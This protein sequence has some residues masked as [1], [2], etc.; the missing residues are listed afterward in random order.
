M[1]RYERDLIVGVSPFERPDPA[2][3]VGLVR[4]GALG[5]LDL[6]RDP[7][8]A[9]KALNE[10]TRWTDESFGVRVPEAADHE[11]A[12]LPD[13]VDTVVLADADAVA[14]WA[15]PGRR[16]LVE[17]RSP[18]EA[19]AALAAGA[20]GLIAKGAES[21]GRIGDL[22]A[23][24]LLQTLVARTDRPVWCQGGIGRHTAAAA[25]AGGAA[26]V[27][28][29]AQLALVRESTLPA[30]VRQAVGAMDGS[31][32]V[33]LGEHRVFTR[34]DLPVASA[35]PD[36]PAADV[37]AALGADDLRAQYL[38]VGQDGAFAKGLAERF[39]TAGG[40]A[41]GL[42]LAIDEHLDAAT[43]APSLAEHST[44]ATTLGTRYPI[45]QG[46]M[47]RVSDRAAFAAAV[48]DGGGLP[49]LALALMS[50]DEVRALLE[51]T[52]PLLGD[53]PWGVGILGFVPPEVREAQLEVVHDVRPPVALIA[54]GR[55]SQAAPLEAAG[56]STFLHVPSPGLLDLF[57]REGARK[58][59]FEG[60]E[61]GGH[62]G[63]RSSFALWDAQ[64]EH[65]LAFGHTDEVSVLFAGGVHDARS[66]AMVGALAAPLAEAGAGV[67]VLMGTSY[68]FTEEAVAGGAILPGF[69]QAAVDC[70]RTVL[71]E[72]SPGHA[73]RC[74]ESD[75]VRA[76]E[77]EK[78]RLLGEGVSVQ[79]AWAELEQLNLGRLR[80]ATKGV[81]REGGQIV[82]VDE[83]GQRREGMFMI[84]QAATLRHEVT[85][86][87][88][89]HD[90]V[91]AGS[92]K[93]LADLGAERAAASGE[94]EAGA[95]LSLDIAI[96]GMAA[97]FAGAADTAHYWSNVVGGVN[98]ITEVPAARWDA[99]RYYD[100][101]AFLNDAGRKT[102][103]RWGGF[104]PEVPFD[105]LAYGI[106]PT[107]LASIEPG[108][109][110]SLEMAARALA[111]AGYATREFDR[112]RTSVVFGAEGGTDLATAY[113]FRALFQTYVGDLPEALDDY[114]PAYTED[115]FP[116]LL[117]N[118]ISGRIANRLDLGGSN[119]TVDAACASALAAIDVACKELVAGTS[120]MVLA[121]GADL[122]NG[123]NDY[124]LFSSVHALSP[125][126]QCRTFDAD[127]DGITLGEGVG[128]LVL[129]RL[130][131][132]ERD[133]DRIY[134]VLRGMAASSDG[135][136]LGLTAPRKEGQRLALD[137]AYDQAGV[138]PA[139]VGLIE[140][141]GTGTVVGDRTELATLTEFF[142]E[143]DAPA[144]ATS[145]GSVK[146]QI[147]HTKCAAGVAGLIKATEAV[148]RRVRPPT[149]NIERPT[150]FYDA[151]TSPFRFDDAARPWTDAQ[152]VAGVSAFGF[153]G[154][155]FHAV[156]SSYDGAPTPAH[157]LDRWP[158]E[159]FVFRGA[160]QGAALVAIDAVAAK[161][162]AERRPGLP[163]HLRDLAA[164]AAERA[165]AAAHAGDPVQV[166]VVADDVDDLLAKLEVARTFTADKAGVVV[167]D[168][169]LQEPAG[170]ETSTGKLAFLF[171][172]QGSQR[173]G[174]LR[175]LFVAFPRLQRH[176]RAPYTDVM[177]PPAAHS[178][179][180]VKAQKEAI[181]DTRV[182]QPTLGI[183]GLAMYDLLTTLGVRP[184]LA[185]GHS[186]GELVA[187]AAAGALA[188]D[189]LVPLSET[190]ARAILGA[191][192]D[193][194]GAMA[195]VAGKGDDVRAVLASLPAEH[196]VVLANDNAPGQAV[197]SGPTA[198]V[199]VAVA[200]LA[201]AGL[202]SK[203]LPV[204]CAFHCPVVADA[205]I[206]LGEAVAEATVAAPAFPVWS[207]TT[208]EPYPAGVDDVRSL[209]SNQVAEPVRWVDEIESMY[210]AGARV[211]VES[212]PGRVLTQ[213]V[214]KILGDRPH[215]AVACDASGEDGLRRFLVALAQLAAN[216]VDVDV[217]PL[218]DGRDA[219]AE[220]LTAAAKPAGWTI[221]G[222][223]VRGA[224][225]RP[226]AGSLQPVDTAPEVVLAAG[227]FGAGGAAGERD[228]AVLEYLRGAREL[229]A[230]EREVM[231][232]YLGGTVEAAAPLGTV[233]LAPLTT[234]APAAIEASATDAG[235][236]SPSG[237][238]AVLTPDEV[239][240]AVLAIVSERTGYPLDMLDP[241]LDLEADLS[242]DSIKR[243]EI[244]GELA[245][246]V[247]LPGADEGSIDESVVEEL[248]Q[249]KT[250]RGIVDWIGAL[251]DREGAG[252]DA[253]AAVADAAGSD[254]G[255]PGVVVPAATLRY[256]VELAEV[257][258]ADDPPGP[259]SGAFAGQTFAVVDDGQGVALHLSALLE[260]R[261]ATVRL[262]A[263]DDAAALSGGAAEVLD[264]LVHLAFLAHGTELPLATLFA[265][266]KGPVLGGLRHLVVATG[267]GGGFGRGPARSAGD[268]LPASSG[269]HGLA[270]T[271]AREF[272]D[273]RVLAI[274]LDPK[275]DPSHLAEHL[276]AELCAGDGLVD[277]GRTNGTRQTLRVLPA[278]LDE[279]AVA[280]APPIVGAD[281]VVLLT[282]GAR[283]ITARVAVALA[284][285]GCGHLVLVGR[286][287]LPEGDE[288]PATAGAADAVE[289]RK[290][291][292]GEGLKD[293][294]A[295]EA[296]C[297]RILAERE[298]RATLRTIADLGAEATYH[299]ADVRD[300]AALEAIV[301][302]TYERCGRLDGVV[303]GAG[304]LEDRFLR[305][306]TAESFE[307]VFGTKVDGARTLA[308]VVR[309]DVG[310]L[311]LFGSIAGVFGNRG[312]VDYAAAND[313]LDTL[314]RRAAEHLTGRVVSVDWGPWAGTGMVSAELEREYG[315]R[316]IGLIDPD[317]GVACLLH[318]LRSGRADA[319]VVLM[320][321]RPDDLDG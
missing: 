247:G 301:A 97:A 121:G 124:L 65:L 212:G 77:A 244:V 265:Q 161:V 127:A 320:R 236:G 189:D 290:A 190:R 99:D 313:A 307:R 258:P 281:S 166:A 73:T 163:L 241:D 76:F 135:R 19:D 174:M 149:L 159:L 126:G 295:I 221:N 38:P 302:G 29:D 22:T 151:A 270:R 201:E 118:V 319:Q 12:T 113:G 222:H 24:V 196:P 193:D 305:D 5:V 155:N 176:L 204:A 321:A 85:T 278:E 169:S 144:G 148:Y 87:A 286:S 146:S 106:P 100:P 8:V 62:V 220:R 318:E 114:L 310:F 30:A 18:E 102:P 131:D 317:D 109:L 37:V 237:P 105:A 94:G 116:G 32:T 304:I 253:A 17:V 43:A 182:A 88:A 303:H 48:A 58:F 142:G 228:A 195:A 119:Y 3:V 80:I 181:T 173:P 130:A 215:L 60:R 41:Q 103:S 70:E 266:L 28:L 153:G 308:R 179:D 57:L 13:Q 110:L 257:G 261:G 21:G 133:G 298:V 199:D 177:F 306:K 42:R 81:A 49:F 264:G 175:E 26:G 115:S 66:A 44:L 129:K 223:L 16:V 141:H 7:V 36:S 275:D 213:L 68:L 27:V 75:Y 79:D 98:A 280:A 231:L 217:A 218:F 154:T 20:D 268:L 192:G 74:V 140:A 31:E 229:M 35:D 52:A 125:S 289:L 84:G 293:P 91:S 117:T 92:T 225:G 209:L 34:P 292:I 2:L 64:I 248:A 145:L 240:A 311:V 256:V 287:A 156:V 263:A 260:E 262:L 300:A 299:Q 4:A 39:G 171:P 296:A 139:D 160:D 206:A 239:M 226:V 89:L 108:Q 227:G 47:T 284:R 233:P 40:V 250:L 180:E 235:P 282:G 168:A 56:I 254:A 134:G 219:H 252:D 55:P 152:R 185:G 50:G 273:C 187:L 203:R 107:S 191:A 86:V 96:I 259:G 245:D 1:D 51:E 90:E 25:I 78:R 272:P 14:V 164:F 10:V 276:L 69:Q 122:H 267:L 123:V 312:Q 249:L 238:R 83:E 165:A 316:G 183:A 15:T 274:D 71:L 111:D 194:P 188:E 157:G 200:A 147:G 61:C 315:R 95:D 72:T 197:I 137:R 82:E 136:H 271:V 277:V 279:D 205:R 234:A 246:R 46:P 6:G 150:D 243:I 178:K 269:A 211:F 54:G 53:R 285:E 297:G 132:A 251:G 184:D 59:I 63:P 242:I 67:G 172:G 45:A 162:P 309:P 214:G 210:A 255:E 104:L 207:N 291:L 202:K 93:Y 314:A 167:P 294:A 11:T 33:V 230:A 216:G 101:D 224:D 138:S 143:A 198:S 9:G 23:Y 232:R 288:D 283:G 128:C 186:Y 158:S 208:A 120:D 112:A 170:D